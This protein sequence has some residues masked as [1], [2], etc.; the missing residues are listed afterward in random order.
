MRIIPYQDRLIVL[1]H[2]VQHT[3]Y[4]IQN[5]YGIARTYNIVETENAIHTPGQYA[6]N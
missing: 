1:I 3:E 2:G 4:N 6:P 5:Y